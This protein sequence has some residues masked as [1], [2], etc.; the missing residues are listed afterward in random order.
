M[1]NE[2]ALRAA[3]DKTAFLR[4]L[5]NRKTALEQLRTLRPVAAPTYIELDTPIFILQLPQYV[6]GDN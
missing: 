2:A 3:S 4:R 6:R 1:R 5:A